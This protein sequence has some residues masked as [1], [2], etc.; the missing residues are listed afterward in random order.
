MRSKFFLVFLA[1]LVTLAG[2][3]QILTDSHYKKVVVDAGVATI[4]KAD[5]INIDTLILNDGAVLSVSQNS[6]IVVNNAF[7]GKEC[8]VVSGSGRDGHD[9]A[10]LIHFR[11][12]GSLVI[13]TK[14]RDGYHGRDGANGSNGQ[15]GQNGEDGGPGANGTDGGNAGNLTLLYVSD[16]IPVFE[17]KGD[18]SIQLEYAGGKGGM[19]GNG[20]RGGRGGANIPPEVFRDGW[21]GRRG[22]NGKDGK[23]GE[24]FLQRVDKL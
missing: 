13:N 21:H 16:V 2:Y 1:C 14:G 23:D 24:L 22:A 6:V 12:L 3:S 9:L 4:V 8:R 7:I 11:T 20:G 5:S 18:R 17:G 19:G 15:R 10:L